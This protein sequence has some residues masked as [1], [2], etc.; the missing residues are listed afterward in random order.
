MQ[1][2]R[3]AIYYIYIYMRE[4]V[5]LPTR[6]GKTRS[7]VKEHYDIQQQTYPLFAIYINNHRSI[8]SPIQLHNYQSQCF[9]YIRNK[10]FQQR[11]ASVC[12]YGRGEV[13]TF[14]WALGV[15]RQSKSFDGRIRPSRLRRS[16]G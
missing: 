9:I 14:T 3:S 1:L 11:K 2:E 15:H 7:R 12:R 10:M 16:F 4:I 8:I 13:A 6:K 5:H